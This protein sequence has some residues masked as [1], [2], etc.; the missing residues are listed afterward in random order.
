M[1]IEYLPYITVAVFFL[2][3]RL[4]S[5]VRGRTNVIIPF[6]EPV[7]YILLALTIIPYFYL[8]EDIYYPLIVSFWIGYIDGY[9]MLGFVNSEWV[10]DHDI[11]K[12]TQKIREVVYYE[13]KGQMYVQPQRFI[14]VCKALF[15]GVRWPLTM[16]LE[17]VYRRR[18]VTFEGR[19][20]KLEA[21]T[22]DMIDH[23]RV[24]QIHPCIRI[25]TYKLNRKGINRY[26]DD[27]IIG[28][29]KYLLHFKTY[30]D[31]Y[32][33]APYNTDAPYDFIRKTNIYKRAVRDLADAKLENIDLEIEK[34]L[35][36]TEG[37]AIMLSKLVKLTPEDMYMSPL[38]NEI[39]NEIKEEDRL[40]GERREALGE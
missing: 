17:T 23:E 7:S 11:S 26:G 8:E 12:A 38:V 14:D 15:F 27:S 33:I 20:I 30:H 39:E 16:P 5:L 22:V 37:G 2:S 13:R 36:T 24:P 28:Q 9:I 6:N 29:P 19:F 10:G 40:E 4:G 25:G 1:V 31:I 21:E 32:K 3:T 34:T 35:R 18:H